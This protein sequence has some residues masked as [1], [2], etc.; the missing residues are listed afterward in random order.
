M[1]TGGRRDFLTGYL[2]VGITQFA[3]FLRPLVFIPIISRALGQEAYGVYYQ[4]LTTSLFLG[5]LLC[6]RLFVALTRYIAGST[7]DRDISRS[8]LFGAVIVGIASVVVLAVSEMWPRPF[9]QVIF[10]SWDLT[11]YVRPTI[12]YSCAGSFSTIV[13]SY[14]YT[15]RRQLAYS[16]RQVAAIVGD[17]ILIYF[18]SGHYA[19][20]PCVNALAAWQLLIGLFVLSEIVI[21]HGWA[22]PSVAG[23]PG[24]WQFT[25][26]MIVQHCILF[27][28]FYGGRY[29]IV[30]T[31]GL[32][33]SAVYGVTS[34]VA[35]II[36]LVSA[37]N[38]IVLMPML[39][40]YWNANR[41]D[42]ARPVIRVAY[43]LVTLLG[44]VGLGALMQLGTP[45]I[46]A[47][48]GKSFLASPTLLLLLGAGVLFQG[49]QV[50]SAL[51]YTMTRKVVIYQFIGLLGAVLNVGLSLLLITSLGLVGAGI[52]FLAA[53]LFPLVLIYMNSVRVFGVGL[54]WVRSAK[55]AVLGVIVYFALWP[56]NW[57]PVGNMA[58]VA[59]GVGLTI[60][61][62]GLGFFALRIYRLSELRVLVARARP[63]AAAAGPPVA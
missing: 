16:I 14:Y 41:P 36:S 54:D 20:G 10:G 46:L 40:A 43:L 30:P 3:F 35:G 5:P 1:A 34:Q 58:R 17:C 50:I 52:A 38:H 37:P 57:L 21:R 49:V 22:R 8:Y 56:V 44:A 39:S 62:A 55:S 6:L 7:S 32:G 4:V 18:L 25:L 9:A 47:L 26:W 24:L 59:I 28:A 48:S 53:L 31:L 33:M 12:L 19:I 13:T 11:Q 15:M 27:L 29:V 51:S 2:I 61:V 60:L 23:F 45:L 42:L 63:G